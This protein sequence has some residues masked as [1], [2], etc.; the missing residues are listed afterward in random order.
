M[1]LRSWSLVTCLLVFGG[2]TGLWAEDLATPN[3][4]YVELTPPSLEDVG[5]T[6]ERV[7]DVLGDEPFVWSARQI[8]ALQVDSEQLHLVRRRR[9]ASYHGRKVRIQGMYENAFE[10]MAIQDIW[11][12][13]APGAMQPLEESEAVKRARQR[14]DE[15]PMR[16]FELPV[17]FWGVLDA[18]RGGYG[19]LDG[20]AAELTVERV[21]VLEE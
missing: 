4:E 11:V 1:I 7:R 3:E 5:L 21:E 14:A 12:Q 18:E 10:H 17:R 2:A 16:L 13:F 8:R 9:Y 20:Y 15:D 6:P 19:H